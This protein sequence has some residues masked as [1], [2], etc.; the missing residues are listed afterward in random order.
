MPHLAIRIPMSYRFLMARIT[1]TQPHA[2]AARI[3]E[4]AFE[5][6]KAY[7]ECTG[8]SINSVVVEAVNRFLTD[9][10]RK[11]EV[12]RLIQETTS[13]HA[14]ALEKLKHL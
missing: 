4:K 2:F 8:Q 1:D 9:D 10:E 12:E 14:V 11:A 5:A 3:P 6:L 7:S 13:R